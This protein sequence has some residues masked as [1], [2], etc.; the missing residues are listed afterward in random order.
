MALAIK[1]AGVIPAWD[2]QVGVGGERMGKKLGPE[3]ALYTGIVY[4][5][6]IVSKEES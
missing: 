1:R 6:F 5:L 2:E 4:A 3:H